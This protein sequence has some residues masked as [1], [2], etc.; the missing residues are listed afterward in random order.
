M[1]SR[2]TLSKEQQDLLFDLYYDKGFLFGRDRLFKYV[3]THHPELNI[4][5]RQVMEWLRKQE[6][7][8]LYWPARKTV[9]IRHTV[10]KEP[11]SQIGI[12]LIDMS[13]YEYDGY[14]WILTA[15]DLFSKMAY[16][17]PMKD[18]TEAS[19][20]KA[21]KQLLDNEI[22]HVSSIRS[23]N[24]SEFISHSFKKLLKDRGISQVLSKPAKPQSNGGIERFNKTMKRYL[25]MG[26]YQ[27]DSKDWVDLVPK[28]VETYNK[29]RNDVTGITP[30]ELNEE[31]DKKALK[32]I[33]EK[34]HRSVESKNLSDG[35]KFE[36][37][38]RVRRKLDE[39]ER[40]DGQT[41]SKAIFKVYR[42]EKPKKT[43]VSS[44]AY[45]IKNKK[46]KFSIKFYQNDL[47]LVQGVE[48][49]KTEK[50]L[51]TIAKLIKP[52]F[53]DKKP[54][55]VVRWKGYGPNDDTIEPRDQLLEDVPKLVRKFERENEVIWYPS[56][57]KWKNEK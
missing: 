57:V 25:K 21:M 13:K 15:Y 20:T 56:S 31:D 7:A 5:R 53:R 19:A 12:D 54:C 44:F 2:L 10:L 28:M 9:D 46:E 23:D 33:K 39:D 30:E 35:Q 49:E 37:G 48:N 4:S 52:V 50:E 45:Y 34:I 22:H 47:Q 43:S 29:T 3:N 55:Y 17:V 18:K 42:V 36:V 11:H 40:T 16:A 26:M 24:G 27:S 8:Q 32:L 6:T 14:K 41:W 51:F 1:T 38:D